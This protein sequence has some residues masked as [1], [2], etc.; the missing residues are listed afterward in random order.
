MRT[1]GWT[2]S[3]LAGWSDRWL[4]RQAVRLADRRTHAWR[5]SSTV[6]A[7]EVVDTVLMSEVGT[8]LDGRW[9]EADKAANHPRFL[10]RHVREDA[11][12][13]TRE[14]PPASDAALS[15]ASCG[16]QLPTQLSSKV[17]SYI[18]LRPCEA[19]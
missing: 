1:D 6:Q 19:R 13:A 14:P 2:A 7:E 12:A 3:R 15:V 17:T 8:S 4:V 18:S 9:Q 16:Q 10:R 11:C 5:L